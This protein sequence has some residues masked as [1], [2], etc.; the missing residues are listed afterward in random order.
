[1]AKRDYYEVLG[2]DRGA[3][4]AELKRVYRRLAM[5]HH[6][7]RNPN[8]P[9]AAERMKELN[10]AYAVLSDPQ[11]RR[12]YGAYGHAGLDGYSQEDLFRGVDFSS[13]F[14]DL[15]LRDL[16]GGGLFGSLFG[17]VG[18]RQGPRRGADLRYDLEVTLEEVASGVA[19]TIEVTI[20]EECPVCQGA[21]A[22]ANGLNTCA[23]CRGSG[24]IVQ[25]QRA[26]GMLFRQVAGCPVCRGRGQTIT[27]DCKQCGGM[28]SQERTRELSVEI[29]PGADAGNAVRLPGEGASGP[30]GPGDLLV[31]LHVRPHEVFRKEE[32]NLIVVKEIDFATAALGGN[33]PVPGLNETH[34][35][36]IPEG[37]QGGSTYRI[38]GAGLPH[39]YSSSRGDVYV[40][41]RV[42]TPTGLSEEERDLFARL[43]KLRPQEANGNHPT[44]A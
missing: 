1:M 14:S 16:F 11:K 36:T 44:D 2:A 9:E 38:P 39:L 37:A 33:L 41:V 26:G 19:K 13:L 12:V 30:G 29:P 15:G 20:D 43:A 18:A 7:D 35:L 24:Q 31:V 27:E 28:G 21:G 34:T 3:D 22:E 6:P 40:V 8:D 42:V 17:G 4:E 23:R 10:E 5:E 32:D 25:D